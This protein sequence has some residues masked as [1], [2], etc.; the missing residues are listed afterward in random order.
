MLA[1]S[2]L[3][4]HI[5]QPKDVVRLRF[6]HPLAGILYSIIWS[7]QIIVMSL[8]VIGDF[9]LV[10][11]LKAM[12][13][14]LVSVIATGHVYPNEMLKNPRSRN[15]AILSAFHDL[16]SAVAVILLFSFG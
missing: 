15:T 7:A 4:N 14:H 12:I 9:E 1:V 5:L 16:W 2:F 3:A 11:I 13:I 8:I 10:D 6:T